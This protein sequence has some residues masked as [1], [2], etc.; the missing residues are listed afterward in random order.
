MDNCTYIVQNCVLQG[1]TAVNIIY[2]IAHS[3]IAKRVDL[4]SLYPDA[5]KSFGQNS[6]SIYDKKKKL[7]RRWA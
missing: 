7:S 1:S 3:N 5:E 2:C 6:T 4:K